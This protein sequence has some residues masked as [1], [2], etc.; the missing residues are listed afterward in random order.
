MLACLHEAQSC[1][2]YL[3]SNQPYLSAGL[4]GRVSTST[5]HLLTSCVCLAILQSLT[6]SI[7]WRSRCVAFLQTGRSGRR[8]APNPRAFLPCFRF[9]VASLIDLVN[10]RYECWFVG[11]WMRK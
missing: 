5:F 8:C 11:A 3:N 9:I 7:H 4:D 6:I 2:D 10:S 1:Q